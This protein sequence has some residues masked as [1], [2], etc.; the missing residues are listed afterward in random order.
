M[1]SQNDRL[2]D[3]I[4]DAA[5]PLWG[6]ASD[7][8]TLLDSYTEQARGLLDGGVDAFLIETQFDLAVAKIAATACLDA[9][10]ARVMRKPFSNSEIVESVE[11]LAS[12]S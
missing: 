10:S 9:G 1:T 5:H 12:G 2:I 7:Y 6:Q 8:D 4:R 3:T 11:A